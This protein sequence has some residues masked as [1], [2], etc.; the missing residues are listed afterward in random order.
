MLNKSRLS[1]LK[2]V[3]KVFWKR[4]PMASSALTVT[5]TGTCQG[6]KGKIAKGRRVVLGALHLQ[7]FDLKVVPKSGASHRSGEGEAEN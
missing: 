2:E 5:D 7:S 1:N 4:T 3:T 6:L